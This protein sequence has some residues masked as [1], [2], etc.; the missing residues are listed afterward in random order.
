MRFRVLLFAFLVS[1]EPR[2]PPEAPPPRP[3]E[4]VAS[5]ASAPTAVPT[6]PP[7]ATVA[8]PEPPP[9]QGPVTEAGLAS[10]Y[11]DARAGHKTASGERFDPAGLT[12]AHRTLRSPLR[13]SSQSE[14]WNY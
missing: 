7:Q 8:T 5:V 4:P 13:E 1:C 11:G 10:W 3:P 14:P 6:A 2:R 12:A 9:A